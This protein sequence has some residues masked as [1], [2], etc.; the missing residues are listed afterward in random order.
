MVVA[1]KNNS[2]YAYESFGNIAYDYKIY[3]DATE[4][5]NK[6]NE[7]K[8]RAKHIEKARFIK[9]MKLLGMVALMLC[10]G[11][12][13]VGRYALMASLTSQC[14]ELKSK[15]TENQKINDDL[16]IQLMKYDDIKQIEKIAT[17]ELNMVRPESN[18]IVHINVDEGSSNVAS[19]EN[20]QKQDSGL[21]NKLISFFN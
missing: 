4:K 16:K 9:Q 21:I 15:I 17:T 1:K 5:E 20:T 12:F 6:K 7:A 11:V 8:R 3:E 19:A 18:N 14:S 10:T 13:I 2:G